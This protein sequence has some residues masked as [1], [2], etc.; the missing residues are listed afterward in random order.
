M[1]PLSIDF[2]R[3]NG[4]EFPGFLYWLDVRVKMGQNSFCQLEGH[5]AGALLLLQINPV[6]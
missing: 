6:R 1:Q 3:I 4:K 2:S 5:T